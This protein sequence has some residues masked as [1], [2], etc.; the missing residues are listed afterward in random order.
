MDT[1]SSRADYRRRW[2]LQNRA[3]ILEKRRLERELDPKKV[4]EKQARHYQN[5]KDYIKT[6]VAKYKETNYKKVLECKRRHSIEYGK[7]YRQQKRAK[8][9]AKNTL[10]YAKKKQRTPPWLSKD[11]IKEIEIIYLQCPRGYHVDH[12]VPLQ[13]EIVSGLHVPWN[14]QHLPAI[15]N[16]RKSNNY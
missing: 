9:L 1:Q 13:G 3:R 7:M 5:R 4:K 10:R 6:R 12:I 2:Y 15:D 11:Q 16:I 14:L 8:V